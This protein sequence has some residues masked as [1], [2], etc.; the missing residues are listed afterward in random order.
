LF[1]LLLS[2]PEMTNPGKTVIENKQVAINPEFAKQVLFLSQHLKCSE[3][4][5]ATLLDEVVKDHP[6]IDSV[7]SLELTVE[8][9]HLRRRH[10]VDSLRCLVDATKAV[11][12]STKN[13]VYVRIARYFVAELVPASSGQDG[14]LTLVR[15]IWKQIEQL[16]VLVA[17]ADSAR[18]GAATNTVVPV[19][20]G[21]SLTWL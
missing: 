10:L 15:R 11:D 12:S 20:Q 8:L 21:Q 6:V 13:Q 18:R 4:Y 19:G 1:T 9:F 7:T 17:Q 14:S 2:V 5:I 16:N 3:R